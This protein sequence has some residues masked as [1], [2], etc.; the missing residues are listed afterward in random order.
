MDKQYMQRMKEFVSVMLTQHR[1]WMNEE[2]TDETSTSKKDQD[3]H[4]KMKSYKCLR[5]SVRTFTEPRRRIEEL[6]SSRWSWSDECFFHQKLKESFLRVS[7]TCSRNYS[8]YDGRSTHSLDGSTFFCC[9]VC[10][11]TSV[12]LM[13]VK[14]ARLN[15]CHKSVSCA[16]VISLHLT[17]APHDSLVFLARLLPDHSQLRPH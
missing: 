11:R 6:F 14:H 15:W 16:C 3:G 8:A 5:D 9:T 12:Q 13:R 4:G 1:Q 17:F 10:L 7:Y 2:P